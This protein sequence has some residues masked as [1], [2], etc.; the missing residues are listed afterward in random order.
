MLVY[1]TARPELAVA[2][3]ATGVGLTGV[4]GGVGK[5]IVCG[6]P[7]LVRT[8]FTVGKL[9]E[10]AVTLY[11]PP[12]V[13]FAVKG[14]DA[15]PEALV[16]T[17]IA[18]KPLLNKPDAPD[19]GAANATLIPETG[20]PPLSFNVTAGAFGKA[21]LMGVF[22]GVVPALAVMDAGVAETAALTRKLFS[23]SRKQLLAKFRTLMGKPPVA[24]RSAGP[25]WTLIC[26]ESTKVTGRPGLEDP[27]TKTIDVGEKPVPLIVTN[28]VDAP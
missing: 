4:S 5:L 27:F 12:T 15:I 16:S 10:S 7:L 20:L 8:K 19:P 6:V 21:V 13:E 26:C 3:N 11:D 17:V 2:V 18:V 1:V 23:T 22:C 24:V 25:S 14:A 28:C 9:D